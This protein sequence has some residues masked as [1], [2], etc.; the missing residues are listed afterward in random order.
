MAQALLKTVVDNPYPHVIGQ[1]NKVLSVQGLCKTYGANQ[2]LDNVSF[3]LHA[4]ELVAVIGRSG[5]GKSTLLHMLNGTISASQGA[6][7]S[8][9]HG[10]VDR[11]VVTLNSRQMREW[12]TECGMIFQDFCLVPRLD[13]LTN[14]LLGRLSQTSTLKSFFKVF[15]ETDRARA[16]ELLQWMNMLPQAL[17]RAENLSGGQMQRVAI[18][19]ALMQ[20]PRILLADEPVASL[21]PKNTKRIM[22]VLRQVSEQGISVMVNLHSIELV[23]SYCTRVIGIQ[24][25]KI[26]F[27]GH[28]S[29]LTDGLMHELY[30]DEINQ[31]H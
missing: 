25:G 27:D 10:E 12:R 6:I 14:V 17:Q 4:G 22:D 29:Q 21:D 7:L 3:D 13:V 11:D 26:L 5:A 18:C 16:I 2:V 24:R 30:G 23:K 20:N 19:R 1:G 9:R 15:S 8:N 31:L 28:P